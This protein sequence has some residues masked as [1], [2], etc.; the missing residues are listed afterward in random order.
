MGV[1]DS[2]YGKLSKDEKEVIMMDLDSIFEIVT[3]ILTEQ[4]LDENFYDP[5]GI[6]DFERSI[7]LE[8][9]EH[10]SKV[11]PKD[12]VE[13]LIMVLPGDRVDF[14]KNPDYEEL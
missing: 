6:S 4:D 2:T 13:E 12:Y 14:Y 5:D 11:P 7:I 10:L 9:I 8:F 1:L 3:D